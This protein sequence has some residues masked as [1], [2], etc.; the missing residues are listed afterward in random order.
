[1]NPTT[2]RAG[3]ARGGPGRRARAALAVASGVLGHPPLAILKTWPQGP[4]DEIVSADNLYGGN[5]Q[6]VSTTPSARLGIKVTFVQ[7]QR[8]GKAS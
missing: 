4:A 3:E 5:L 2:G 6:P 7:E 8:P 1:M